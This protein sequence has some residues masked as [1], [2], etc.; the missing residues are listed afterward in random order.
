LLRV[1]NRTSEGGGFLARE[2]KRGIKRYKYAQKQKE[3]SD[4]WEIPPFKEGGR[5]V[6]A[7]MLR[8][9]EPRFAIWSNR[10]QNGTLP[11]HNRGAWIDFGI[12]FVAIR[13]SL[14]RNSRTNGDSLPS[15]LETKKVVTPEISTGLDRFRLGAPNSRVIEWALIVL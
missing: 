2:E 15:P 13:K 6:A 3:S 1:L 14:N 12:V 4:Q 10:V 8:V 7:G 9:N 5:I 11:F